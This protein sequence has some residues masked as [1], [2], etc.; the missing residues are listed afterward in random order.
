MFSLEELGA[1]KCGN[2]NI[3]VS[4]KIMYSRLAVS[5]DTKYKVRVHMMYI[6]SKSGGTKRFAIKEK[7]Q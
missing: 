1:I 3:A 6:V 5:C 2:N 4:V 7:E